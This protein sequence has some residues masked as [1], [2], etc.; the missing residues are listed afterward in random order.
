MRK[1]IV[2]F[3]LAVLFSVPASAEEC[4][5]FYRFVDFGQ[6]TSN[7]PIRG[8]P[9]YRAEGF[10]GQALLIRD[11]TLCRQGL[12]L[13]VDGRGNPIPI[14]STVSYDPEK[15]GISLTLLRLTVPESIRAEAERNAAEHR[16]RLERPNTLVGR[17][18]D[19]LCARLDAPNRISCQFVSPFGSDLPLVVYCDAVECRLPIMALNEKVVAVAIWVPTQVV[20]GDFDAATT[21]IGSKVR[22]V[23]GFLAPLSSWTPDFRQL[24]P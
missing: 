12:H 6:E 18:A 20:S 15:T 23:H 8:G 22:Q 14:V 2:V 11:R 24:D 7:G 13:A 3:T 5:V 17:G 21:E 10:D 16:A 19:F 1:I 9:T 4:P